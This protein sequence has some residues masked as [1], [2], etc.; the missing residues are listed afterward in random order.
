MKPADTAPPLVSL[1][2]VSHG[3]GQLV[4]NLLRDLSQGLDLPFEVVL[5]LNLP[6]DEAFIEPYRHLPQ[7]RLQVIRNS[8]RKGFGANHNA[9]FQHCSGAYFAVVNPDIQASELRLAPLLQTLQAGPRV[10]ACAPAVL[11]TSGGIED[12]ARRYPSAARLL[13]RVLLRQRGPDYEWSNEPIVVD[14]VAGMFVVFDRSAFEAVRGFDERYFMYF[15]DADICRR[16]AR[17]G[18]QVRLDP[19]T[20]VV[21]DAQRASHKSLKHLRWHLSSAL[22]FLWSA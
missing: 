4:K 18:W 8:E 7:L 3:Q 14:W 2:V 21:H 10:A 6:E 15:E 9:A 22:R 5:T 1:S 17:A 11:S 16:L 19:R 13:R 12:S 20:R